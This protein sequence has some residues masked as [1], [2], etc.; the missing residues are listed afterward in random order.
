MWISAASPAPQSK[1]TKSSLRRSK[2]PTHL[3]PAPVKIVLDTTIL[4]RAYERSHGLARDLL[5]NVVDS[6]HSLLLSNE[7]LHEVAR[8]LRYPRLQA[9]YGLTES[10]VFDYINF[11]RRASELWT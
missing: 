10:L 5:L 7:M 11:L 2:A 8:V 3:S 4:V 6:Q 1:P 9:F